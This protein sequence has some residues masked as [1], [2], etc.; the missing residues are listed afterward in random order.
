MVFVLSLFS[1]ASADK[2]DDAISWMYENGLTIHNNKTDFNATRWLRRDE[3]AKFYVNFS[4]LLGKTTYVKTANQCVFSDINDSWSDLKDIVVESCRLWLF[5]GSRWKFNPKSQLTNAQAITVLVRLL[6]GN[7]SEVWLSHRANNYYTK[8]NELGVLQSVSMNSKDSIAT[9]GNVGVIIKNWDSYS[10]WIST[11][12]KT[13]PDLVLSSVTINQG[14]SSPKVWNKVIY[15]GFTIRNLGKAI[16]FSEANKWIFTCTNNWIEIFKY[17]I[18][19]WYIKENGDFN[20]AWF[21]SIQSSN[22]DLFP[23]PESNYKLNCSIL[24]SSNNEYPIDDNNYKTITFAVLANNSSNNQ[25]QTN[26]ISSIIGTNY[27]CIYD[28]PTYLSRLRLVGPSTTDHASVMNTCDGNI[29]TWNSIPN[30]NNSINSRNKGLFVIKSQKVGYINSNW[31]LLIPIEYDRIRT[32]KFYDDTLFLEVLKSSKRWIFSD[33][34]EIVPVNFENIDLFADRDSWLWA[35]AKI[36]RVSNTYSNQKQWVYDIYGKKI[37][38]PD[39]YVSNINRIDDW[40]NIYYIA[41][42]GQETY[43]LNNAGNIITHYYSIWPNPLWEKWQ[44]LLL[45]IWSLNGSIMERWLINL[46]WNIVLPLDTYSWIT[47]IGNWQ[48]QLRKN[49]TSTIVN[50]NDL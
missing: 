23:A 1:F 32:R 28:A 21:S 27:D 5:Q 47:Y 2:V 18:K 7:Q 45:S 24:L 11:I 12:E 14:A 37:V 36:I 17:E 42:N 31:Q 20:I 16:S 25:N 41:S 46:Q 9:R 33:I 13:K 49:N 22:V 39:I 43:L 40:S 44:R 10:N 3:A 6:A 48:I 29:Y 34:K 4:K 38:D 8:A 30:S 35:Q 26:N 19:N 50:I 15:G